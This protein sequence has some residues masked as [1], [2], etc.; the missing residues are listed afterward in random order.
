MVQTQ[1]TN[2]LPIH[3]NRI[4]KRVETLPYSYTDLEI[5]PEV[6]DGDETLGLIVKGLEAL[7]VLVNLIL[8]KVELSL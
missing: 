8:G 5:S 3:D 2:E 6:I 7:D 4:A 1:C